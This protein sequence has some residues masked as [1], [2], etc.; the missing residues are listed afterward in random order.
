MFLRFRR[1][2]MRRRGRFTPRR[3][4]PNRAVRGRTYAARCC[5]H[6]GLDKRAPRRFRDAPRNSFGSLTVPSHRTRSTAHRPEQPS[7]QARWPTRRLRPASR[8]RRLQKMP[9]R[10]P[11]CMKNCVP[12]PLVASAGCTIAD[13]QAGR[14]DAADC[15]RRS[16]SRRRGSFGRVRRGRARCC[17]RHAAG[18]RRSL[19]RQAIQ[20][21]DQRVAF[22]DTPQVDFHASATKSNRRGI[23]VEL[24][25]LAA[26]KLERGREQ[27][28]G[29]NLAAAAQ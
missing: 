4:R 27:F 17:A 1:R 15:A 16:T 20:P 22:T 24:Q 28:G 13:C 3:L 12:E 2:L 26:D 9:K 11:S 29:R 8:C 25:V 10:R 19:R 23:R 21:R 6:E 5:R 7:A 18:S 14:W